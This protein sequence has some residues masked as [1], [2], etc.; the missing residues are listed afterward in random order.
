MKAVGSDSMFCSDYSCNAQLVPILHDISTGQT[1]QLAIPASYPMGMAQ[2]ISRTGK[3][4]TG[5]LFVPNM[6]PLE[7]LPV[8]A[9][10]W[11]NDYQPYDIGRL[12][13]YV[14]GTQTLAYA[15]SNT[16]IIVGESNGQAFIYESANGMEALSNYLENLGL[17]DELQNWEA[18]LIARAITPD[19]HYIV[20]TGLNASYYTQAFLIYLGPRE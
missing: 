20:G 8:S 19:G 7:L 4:I 5:G 16:G 10:Y 17:G 9:V 13:S 6:T 3:F 1:T 14:D 18:L 2:G 12:G 15:T 11:D